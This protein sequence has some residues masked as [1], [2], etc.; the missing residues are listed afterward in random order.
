MNYDTRNVVC[1]LHEYANKTPMANRLQL[2]EYLACRE[3]SHHSL[4]AR[5][6]HDKPG[7]SLFLK[8]GDTNVVTTI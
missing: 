6:V 2:P 7:L 8:G 3:A 5:S 1:N 4:R